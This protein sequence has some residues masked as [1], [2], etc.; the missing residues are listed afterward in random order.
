MRWAKQAKCRLEGK[1]LQ[2]F[3]RYAEALSGGEIREYCGD[4]PVRVECAAEEIDLL[5][6]IQIDARHRSRVLLWRGGLSPVELSR[7]GWLLGR[8]RGVD[9]GWTQGKSAAVRR[10]LRS[11]RIEARHEFLELWHELMGDAGEA[12]AWRLPDD[13]GPPPRQG[14]EEGDRVTASL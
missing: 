10:E 8:A 5:A 4:C 11:K 3:A 14:G 9:S 12:V 1:P 13:P 7:L 2:F 6:S